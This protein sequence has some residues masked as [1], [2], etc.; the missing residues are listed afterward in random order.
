MTT[1]SPTTTPVAQPNPLLTV[2]ALP[3]GLPDYGA[4]V[5]EH[6]REAIEAGIAARRG[7][8]ELIVTN[9]EPATVQN[10]LVRLDT[11][12]QLLRRAALAFLTVQL[13][14]A[15]PAITD[16]AAALKP[17]MQAADD[18]VVLDRGLYERIR[19]VDLTDA[20]DETRRLAE[21]LLRDAVHRGIELD[22]AAQQRVR[23]INTTIAELTTEFS[24][25][26]QQE[27]NDAAVLVDTAEELD[28]LSA[29]DLA[30]AAQAAEEAGHPGQ[31]LI[32]LI[33]PSN[34][35]V[36]SALTDS[37][38]RRRIHTASVN[39][40]LGAQADNS[41]ENGGEA[42]TSRT[43]V[44]PI[45]ARVAALRA[46]K[47]QLFGFANYAEYAV[48]NQTAPDYASVRA[49]LERLAPAAVR[50]AGAER[51]ALADAAGTAVEAWDWSFWSD[52]VR[53]ERYGV[54]GAALRPWFELDRVLTDGVF[55]AAHELYGLSFTERT[56]LAGYHPD[57]RVWEVHDADGAGLGLFLGDYWTRPTKNGGAWMNPIVE[58]SRLLGDKPV[59]VNNL[60]LTKPAPGEPALLTLDEVTTC[61]HEFGHAL[62]GLLSD[63]TYRRLSGT[64]VPRDFVEYPSQVNEMWMLWPE[65][66]ANYARH[67]RTGEPLPAE[68]VEKLLA[69]QQWGEGFATTEYLGAALLDLAWHEQT[70]TEPVADP[71]A[72]EQEALAQAGLAVEAVPPRYRTGYFKHIFASEY[73]AGY[74]SYIWSEVLDADTVEWFR[75]NGGLSRENGDT[76]RRELLGRGNS[77]DPLASFRAF[78]GRDAAV[79]PLLARRGLD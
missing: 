43:D 76:F 3:Y 34:Q 67:H 19:A 62:H 28:G 50:N 65:V 30:A 27:G 57:V 13:A 42:P 12:G 1:S 16:L 51:D 4:I 39:R 68:T 77:R 70:D 73:A 75:E 5:P 25:L 55:F 11:A 74:Y 38:T 32:T 41:A 15:T 36:L 44:T 18:D 7:E 9:P 53:R 20:D 66:L 2:S 63:V 37:T 46:E 71:L 49:M 26:V 48:E 31:Y 47:A 21:D 58:Q 60:N 8:I 61:F 40:G 56:D 24:A 72:F 79:D 78:R 45:A 52:A 33:L 6:Y 23:A 10:T 59:V 35:P 54:D 29:D 17:A 14:D 22:D 64:D 69:A